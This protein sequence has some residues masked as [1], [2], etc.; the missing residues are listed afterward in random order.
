MN[1][2]T[3]ILLT[4][5]FSSNARLLF[6]KHI[7]N[8]F[9]QIFFFRVYQLPRILWSKQLGYKYRYTFLFVERTSLNRNNKI[10][11]F[12]NTCNF[13]IYYQQ[14]LARDIALDNA[15]YKKRRRHCSSSVLVILIDNVEWIM[16]SFIVL[17]F[18]RDEN[19]LAKYNR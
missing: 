17:S 14:R 4:S 7:P 11:Y 15:T 13:S 18:P 8:I 16:S 3:F 10:K 5:V 12:N 9:Y 6:R 2:L 19:K 1:H